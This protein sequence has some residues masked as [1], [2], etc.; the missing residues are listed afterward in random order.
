MKYDFNNPLFRLPWRLRR[1]LHSAPRHGEG[2]LHQWLFNMSLLLHR[3]LAPDEIE[4][5]LGVAV[6]DC[7]RDVPPREISDAVANSLALMKENPDRAGKQ[8]RG[9]TGQSAPAMQRKWPPCDDQRRS[10][11]I[12]ASPATLVSLQAASPM[13]VD[14]EE[15]ANLY[16]SLLFRP[17]DLL[18][19]GKSQQVFLTERCS[20]WLEVDFS[21]S[22][23]IV[24]SPMSAKHGMTQTGRKSQHTLSNTGERRYLVTEFD[25]GTHNEQAAIITHLQGALPL[26]MVVHS[27]GKSLHAWWACEGRNEEQLWTFFRNAY[28][29]GADRATWSRSQFVRLPQGWRSNKGRR[30]VVHYFDPG[31]LPESVTNRKEGAP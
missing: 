16:L 7:G 21:L 23:L 10:E 19:I 28:L 31:S 14:P 15:N 5:L 22:C 29:L 26:V 25:S 20:R 11:I 30:Q 3:H 27:G 4:E 2:L 6:K 24:P 17:D 9:S 12:A 8:R 18:C 13:E 1:K